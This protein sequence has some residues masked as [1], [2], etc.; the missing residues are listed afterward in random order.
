MQCIALPAAALAVEPLRLDVALGPEFDRAFNA[1]NL[2]TF[3]GSTKVYALVYARAYAGS[4]P[5]ACVAPERAAWVSAC[6]R[7]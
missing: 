4:V 7:V 2:S 3:E 5:G 6:D 1:C